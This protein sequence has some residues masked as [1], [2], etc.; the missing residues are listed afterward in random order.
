M[1][2]F[3]LAVFALSLGLIVSIFP[4]QAQDDLTRNPL[5]LAQDLL[6]F[7]G[8]A[9]IPDPTPVYKPGDT[10]QFWVTKAGQDTPTQITAD[11]VAAT[12]GLYLWVEQGITMNA[13]QMQ[14]A[15]GR[16]DF[17]FNLLRM[18]DNLGIIQT[19]P[20]S[21]ADLDNYNLL[22]IPDID[23]DPHLF[24]LYAQ[25]LSTNR[26][27]L[28]NPND[29]L[30]TQLVPGGYSNQHEL[31]IV[32]TSAFPGVTFDDNAYTAV[33]VH[34][35]M[36]MFA[37]YNNPHHSPWLSEALANYM[38]LQTAQQDITQADAV[39]FLDAP[40]TPLTQLPG[41]TSQGEEYGAGQLF[42]HYI[43]Q[44][45][46]DAVFHDLFLQ[47]GTGLTALDRILQ[48][49]QVT[50]LVT[51]EPISAE[52]VFADF[53][54]TNVLNRRFGDGRYVYTDLAA[55]NGQIAAVPV[56]TDNFNF[57]LPDRLVNQLGTNYLALTTSKDVNFTLVFQ[58]QPQAARLR[59]PGDSDNHFYWSGNELDQNS[60][61]TRA[62]DLT[63]VEKAQLTFDVWY[64]LI[65][66]WNYAYVEISDDNGKTWKILPT[67][68]TTTLNPYAL[69][70]GPGF[71][72]ISSTET[73]RPFPYLG[74]GLDTNGITITQIVADGP[75]GKTDVVAGDTIAGHDG[76]KWQGT[77]NLIAFLS[78]YKPGD[79]V[80]LYI[81]RGSTFFSVDVVLGKHPTRVVLPDSI[82]LPQKIDLTLYAGKSVLLRFEEV[83]AADTADKGIALDNIA[84]PEIGFSD[85]AEAGVQGWTLNGWQQMTN[86]M[87]QRFLVQYAQINA[88]GEVVGVKQLIGPHDHATNGSWNLSL[89][90]KEI[91]V[92]AISGLN[93]N[94]DIPGVFSLAAQS[95]S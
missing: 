80:N 86:T 23:N 6:G 58:G 50:D 18:T 40:Q 62:F 89:A 84:I 14:A 51:N 49:H 3:R 59:I 68:V 44:R 92:L 81:Q 95:S 12:D 91:L 32:N 64:N 77:P 56:L 45:F 57:Q 17:L 2:K 60:T 19:A 28:F 82:W 76:Q 21:R 79:T 38:F 35:M 7:D 55:A 94:T 78:N 16:L 69:S 41:L 67:D 52:D 47:P 10:L 74:I 29:S 15:A 13:N 73:P 5:Q 11:L 1:L 83:S 75:M 72:G 26:P 46:G 87:P 90:A 30:P 71:T 33:L 27:T 31:I 66:R 4:A 9:P 22:S 65:D 37:F 61:L 70:Y 93:D 63:G 85:D 54:M 20:Q 88:N 8:S 43:R 39:A 53:V 36:N 24:V 42:L 25:E 34:Q 48:R